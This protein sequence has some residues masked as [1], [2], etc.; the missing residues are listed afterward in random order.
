MKISNPRLVVEVADM[1]AVYRGS[2]FDWSGFVTQVTLDKEHTFCVSE[3]LQQGVGTGGI[4]LCCEF[5]LQQ[6]TGYDDARIG[7]QFPKLGVGLL[8]KTDDEPYLAQ[9]PYAVQPFDSRVES[10]AA[11]LRFFIEP[12]PCRGYA[13]RQMKTLRLEENFLVVEH[14]LRNVGS[15]AIHTNEY[16]HN[17]V[18][19]NRQPLGPEYRLRLASEIRVHD[20]PP[21]LSQKGAD[22]RWSHTP[23]EAFFCEISKTSLGASGSESWELLHEPSGVAMRETLNRAASRLALW[24]DSHVVSPEVFLAIEIKPGETQKWVRR[25]EFLKL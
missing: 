2:R 19:I 9:R 10:D 25:H 5:G 23:D 6:P 7:E 3:S 24:C 16:C 22:V 18:A 15:R 21:V 4:G 11:S 8:T 20:A 12:K 13:V 1:G 17:F 14:E